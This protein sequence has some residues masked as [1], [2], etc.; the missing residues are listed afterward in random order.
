MSKA[1]P[2]TPPPS[3]CFKVDGEYWE[4]EALCAKIDGFGTRYNDDEHALLDIWSDMRQFCAAGGPHRVRGE[5]DH[6][7]A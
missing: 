7:S 4:N 5:N 6:V 2:F 3:S 1:R